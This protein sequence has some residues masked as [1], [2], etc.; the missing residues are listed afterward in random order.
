MPTSLDLILEHAELGPHPLRVGHP[1]QLEMP[2]PV[3]PARVRE[4][5]EAKR[6]RPAKATRP[7]PLGG[8]P[9]ELDQP[10]FLGIQF[11]VELCKSFAQ[12]SPEP[13]SVTPMLESH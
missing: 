12:I 1:L 3:L 8:E 9:A 13:L 6:L 10:R 4:A 2:V 11:Q 5:Q 7:P